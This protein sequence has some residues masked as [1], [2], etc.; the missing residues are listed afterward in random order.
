MSLSV[1]R[2]WSDRTFSGFF[3]RDLLV[4]PVCFLLCRPAQDAS[5]ASFIP[6]RSIGTCAMAAA[7]RGVRCVNCCDG[8]VLH[9][10]RNSPLCRYQWRRLGISV[11]ES[12]RYHSSRCRA[13]HRYQSSRISCIVFDVFDRQNNFIAGVTRRISLS[14]RMAIRR[15]DLAFV[16][17]ST[18]A[19]LSILSFLSTNGEWGAIDAV[20]QT[21]QFTTRLAA[22]GIDYRSA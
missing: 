9:A 17:T 1:V 11:G 19:F 3:G 6:H 12:P 14:P 18:T 20:R 2:L 15:R 22:K 4:L 8:R 13:Q 21:S 10:H 16:I 5:P 7:D